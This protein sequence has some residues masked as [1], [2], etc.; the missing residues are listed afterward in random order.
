[1]ARAIAKC[2]CEKCGAEF[3][4]MKHNLRN[5]KEADSWRDWAVYYYDTCDDCR[6]QEKAEEQAKEAEE[7]GLEL[8]TI[9]YYIYKKVCPTCLQVKD[10]YNEEE[11]TVDIYV[12]EES[13][14]AIQAFIEE[15]SKLEIVEVS[16]SEY[17]NNYANC[18]Q[19]SGSYNRSTKTIQIYV[20]RELKNQILGIEEEIPEEPA[21]PSEEDNASSDDNNTNNTNE[22]MEVNTMNIR[23]LLLKGTI[24][25]DTEYAV[26]ASNA[27]SYQA[28][29]VIELDA[30]W[31]KVIKKDYELQGY[32]A[33]KFY[34]AKM[35]K[36]YD[37]L[38]ALEEN[39][40]RTIV[41][42]KL[43]DYIDKMCDAYKEVENQKL[44]KE[45]CNLYSLIYDLN[46]DEIPFESIDELRS[47]LENN[48]LEGYQ[49][50]ISKFESEMGHDAAEI[51]AKMEY[52]FSYSKATLDEMIENGFKVIIERLF[53]RIRAKKYGE[54]LVS[55]FNKI[56]DDLN[57]KQGKRYDLY[58]TIDDDKFHIVKDNAAKDFNGSWIH[59][60]YFMNDRYCFF[61]KDEVEINEY[62][63]RYGLHGIDLYQEFIS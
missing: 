50:T 22:N 16:Y 37:S 25:N 48:R 8:M 11:K 20:T 60:G 2:T 44:Y 43:Y 30:G 49:N 39:E 13:K 41:N 28:M 52:F 55:I 18:K 62:K 26:F 42:T 38:I 17:K 5:R 47:F 35:K 10:S 56:I 54:E 57:R 27:N 46:D 19:V 61:A 40:F 14:K 34:N 53:P 23:D 6:K 3:E 12:D 24:D 4:K 45:A 32:A 36:V 29:Y 15:E 59:I 63:L 21:T 58:F 1:M 7:N 51:L 31:A 33:I 9:K